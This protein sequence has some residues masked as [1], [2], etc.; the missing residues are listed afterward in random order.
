MFN[1]KNIETGENLKNINMAT[2]TYLRRE[3]VLL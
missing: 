1:V 3:I 2:L